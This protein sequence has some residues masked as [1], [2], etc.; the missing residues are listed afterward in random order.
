MR[1]RSSESAPEA[2]PSALR[3]L[4]GR[5]LLCLLLLLPVSGWTA[6]KD[7]D[8]NRRELEEIRQRIGQTTRTLEEKNRAEKSAAADLQKVEKTLNVMVTRTAAIGSQL[9]QLNHRIRGLEGEIGQTGAEIDGLSNLV[10]RR[11]VALYKGGGAPLVQTLFSPQPTAQIEADLVYWQR[12]VRHDRALLGG[13]RIRLD[14]QQQTLQQLATLRLEQVRLKA[15]LESQRT[16]MSKVARMKEELLAQVRK[17]KDSL[18]RQL[19]E[20]KSRA[21]RVDGL[22]RELESTRKREPAAPGTSFAGQKGRLDWPVKG[23]VR[24]PF[25]NSRHPELGT[26]YQSHGIEIEV[27]GATSVKAVWPGRVAFANPFKGYGNLLIVDHGDGYYTLYAQTAQPACK[28]GDKVSKGQ[29]I[30]QS[31]SAAGRFYF[32]IRKGGTPL[33]PQDWL[34]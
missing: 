8:A 17:D 1:S 13:Y 12:I 26:P 18:S 31:D 15:E 21:A 2:R 16:E 10:A 14:T 9:E 19:T 34:E 30:A 33:D 7:L 3:V 28:V 24:I 11:V 5:A 6:G 25:G 23:R 29:V 20:L 22:I 4:T 27:A 32:E